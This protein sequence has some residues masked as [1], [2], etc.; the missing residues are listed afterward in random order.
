MKSLK[1]LL[2]KSQHTLFDPQDGPHSLLD[3]AQGMI[4]GLLLL[5]LGV[6]LFKSAGVLT[7]GIMGVALFIHY[8]FE[9]PLAPTLVIINIPFYVMGYFRFGKWFAI[10][11]TLAVGLLALMLAF[12]PNWLDIQS[13][14][15]YFAATAGGLLVGV[16]LI[17]L[18]RHRSST[19]GFNVLVLYFQDKFGWNAGI[20]QMILDF[21]VIASSTFFAS[22][23]IVAASFLGA[24]VLN[25]SISINH[26]PGRYISF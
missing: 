6:I 24:A 13:V 17:M 2:S 12:I 19:G 14:N 23:D 26:R 11:S 1:L 9:L 22:P 3:D 20:C 5:S 4:T 8:V 21:L 25:L 16:G 7:G 10:K 15:P 18:F